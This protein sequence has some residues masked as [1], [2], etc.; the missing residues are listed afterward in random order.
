M[1]RNEHIY[2]KTG[3]AL[4]L[5]VCAWLGTMLLAL[6]TPTQLWRLWGK[7]IFIFFSGMVLLLLVLIIALSIV[8]IVSY[9][10][11]TGKYPYYFL[12]GKSPSAG[13]T[14]GPEQKKETKDSV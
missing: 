6:I 11:W 8:R 10:R 12:F 7:G 5:V 4:I 9:I 14:S 3:R 2:R 1:N 13:G